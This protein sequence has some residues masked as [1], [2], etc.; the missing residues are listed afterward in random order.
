[1]TKFELSWLI[2][3]WH[4]VERETLQDLERV[5]REV[6]G[7]YEWN[8]LQATQEI[9]KKGIIHLCLTFDSSMV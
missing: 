5:K 9:L 4:E 8:T 2:L 3:K 6:D 7:E 1:M